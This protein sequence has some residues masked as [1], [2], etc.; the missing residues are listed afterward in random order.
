MEKKFTRTNEMSPL[1]LKHKR[2]SGFFNSTWILLLLMSFL[3]WQCE[4]DTFEGETKGVCPEVIS[5]DPG[6]GATNVVTNKIITATFNEAMVPASI[7]GETFS[8][9]QGSV[10]VS[11]IVTYAGVIATFTP[12]KPLDAN[13]TY[14]GTVTKKVKDPDGNYPIEN[15]TWSFSTGNVPTVISTDPVTAAS[16]VPLNK[17]ITATFSTAMDPSTINT[18]TFLV[19]QGTNP[20]TGTVAYSGVTATFTPASPLSDN[21]VYTGTITI[22]AKDVAGNAMASHYKW[23]FS[24]AIT[25][26][27][28]TISLSS[29]PA[30]GGSTGG[31]GMFN[32]DDQITAIATPVTGY[33]FTN[34]TEGATIVS[35]NANY[36]FTATSNRAL[37]A[38]FTI[39]TFALT[40]SATNGSVTKVPNQTTFNYGA[41]VLL[42]AVPNSGYSFTGWSG[43]ATG[44]SNSLTIV[45][46][47]NKNITANFALTPPNTFTLNVTATLGGSTAKNPNLTGYA[48]GA[49]V[50]VTATPNT[51][52]TFAGW[53]GNATGTTNP[54]SVTMN[55]DKNIIANF[56]LIPV[57]TYS[58][59]VTAN[60]GVVVKNPNQANYNQGSTVQLTATPNTGYTFTGWTGDATGTANPLTV[61]M[62]SNKNI[63]ANFTL[64]PANTYTLNVTAVNGTVVKNPNQVNYDQGSTVQ[65]TATPNTG[66]TFTGW[67]GDATG[68]SNSLTIV[69][70]SNKNITANFALTP[71]NTFTLNVT[72]TLGGTTAKNP[73]LIS[74]TSGAVVQV[75]ATPNTGYTFAG[76]T[77][78]ATGTINPLSVTMNSD[79]NIIA[80]FTLIP[81]VTYSL[82]VIAN[83]G[84]VVKNPNQANYNQGS[85]VQLTATPNTGYTFTGWTGDATGTTNPLTVTMN[86][87]KNITANFTLIPANTYTLN[88]TAV[89]GTVVKNPNQV[90][91]DQGSTVQLTAT[92]NTGYTFTGWSVD[93]TGSANPLTVTMNSN[94]NITAIFTLIPA[95]TYTLNINAVNGTVVKNPNQVNYDQGSTVQL[96]ATPNTG[97]TF[98]GWS[99]DAT[100]SANPLTVTMNSNKSITAIFTLM[101]PSNYTLNVTAINGS[102]NKDPNDPTYLEGATVQL[103]A[104]PNTG[105]T[106]TSW[107]GDA[108]GT[109]NP[110]T[111]MMDANKEIVANFSIITFTLS[112]ISV[113]GDVV[114][115]PE[116]LEYNFGEN[117]ELTATPNSGYAFDS[118]SGDAT[119]STNPITVLM[120]Q[121]KTVTANYTELPPAGPLA[122]ELDC[123][124]PYGVLAGSTITSTGPSVINGDVGLNP[125]SALEGFPPGTIN[126]TIH[127][128][129]V[130]A[131]AKGCLTT[132][133]N[134]GQGRSLNAISLPGQ[135][136]GLTLPPGLYSN[137]S[138]SGISGTGPQGILTLDAQ[139]NANAVWIFQMGS[140]L[141]TD[142]GTSIV[143]A[144]NAQAGNIFWIVGTSATLG[145]TSVFYGNILADQ[146]ITLNTGAV[147]NGRALTRIA[148]V[149]LDA[150]TINIP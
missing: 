136:G 130:A 116:Q 134:D 60:N 94:K 149:T 27:Q 127:I 89:N 79:K 67:T 56:T 104:T 62:N 115:N 55:S 103:E 74:Y 146:S 133:Y 114:K 70:N 140:T 12:T 129:A 100:G 144:G 8:I 111:V 34:W 31:G 24:T 82:N 59:N 19:N 20:I 135:L 54:L 131:D 73:D 36:A 76:W 105:Y 84:V 99:G 11:G 47:S 119:G 2:H 52:Y 58:L 37:V 128:D 44:T 139:G 65:L 113:N 29:N 77:G 1:M 143:L 57:I 86:S 41:S 10:P 97:Y 22:G 33:T 117:V 148:A 48:S 118:W 91:Y 83:N 13:K 71:P 46:N 147:L 23:S 102:V 53:S 39:N 123:A 90:N 49:V 142:P 95:T 93:A 15:Y 96:T 43:D 25:L 18:A 68:T 138:S 78:D 125:G 51:G 14:T 88:V 69:M 42:T 137:S 17:I 110:L 112:V 126:G 6:N 101:P 80:N 32:N 120:D 5:S 122:I 150:S 7:N 124:A 121:N 30:E 132:A 28:Y 85:T 81:V 92:P 63:T 50:Q 35:S 26:I 141:T 45:M 106:F 98:T 107:G 3:M 61:T 75:T 72:A 87:N 109:D 66:Y 21:M 4:K 40:I 38:N 108:T 9:K 64:I 16:S 145:T